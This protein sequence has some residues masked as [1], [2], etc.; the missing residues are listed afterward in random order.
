[1]IANLCL[2]ALYLT[3][4]LYGSVASLL[5]GN[6]T[7]TYDEIQKRFFVGRSNFDRLMKGLSELSD[8]IFGKNIVVKF[9]KINLLLFFFF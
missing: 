4:L 6:R 3:L 9:I 2:L 7:F 5:T 8:R 1:M